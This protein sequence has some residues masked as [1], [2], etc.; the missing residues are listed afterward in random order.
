MII[1]PFL[2]VVAQKKAHLSFDRSSFCL[3]IFILISIVSIL[4]ASDIDNLLKSIFKLK[5]FLIGLISIYPIQNYF[6]T[7]PSNQ[8]L[9]I[10]RRLI[11]LFLISITLA[12]ISGLIGL[13]THF[14][15]LKFKHT[16][17]YL[18]STGMYGMAITYGYG[19]GIICPIL[20]LSLIHI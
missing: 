4:A 8:K 17:D 3:A 20:L 15:P 13:I 7:I 19:I 18:R 12:N 10:I 6:Q 2:I 5:Y 9:K 1:I 16:G 11:N 14:N